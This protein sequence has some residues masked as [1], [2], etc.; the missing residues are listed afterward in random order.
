MPSLRVFTCVVL[1]M[2]L[3]L[4]FGCLAEE[5]VLEVLLVVD[6][7]SQ[8]RW[9]AVAKAAG[10][11]VKKEAESFMFEVNKCFRELT[12][13][14]V[15]IEVRLVNNSVFFTSEAI[16]GDDFLY[17]KKGKTYINHTEVLTPLKEWTKGKQFDIA[18]FI[19]GHTFLDRDVA[20][21][22]IINHVCKRSGISII[23]PTYNTFMTQ[24]IVHE[25]GHNLGLRHDGEGNDCGGD[26][27]LFM[28]P[29]ISRVS[30]EHISWSSCSADVLRKNLKKKKCIKSTD[31]TKAIKAARFGR[32]LSADE[33]C[34][35]LDRKHV[36][37]F[38][39]N[40]D[41]SNICEKLPCEK[42]LKITTTKKK[43]W[44]ITYDED[45]KFSGVW[46]NVRVP[47]GMQC[48]S[49]KSCEKGRCVKDRSVT[50]SWNTKCPFGDTPYLEGDIKTCQD[51]KKKKKCDLNGYRRACCKSCK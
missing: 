45:T 25:L 37:R 5:Y 27:K 38:A 23:K 44:F 41:Y 42:S 29:T 28:A 49:G 14:G 34:K 2:Y 26:A 40:H 36:S 32:I 17:R 24:T 19:P 22:A 11:T 15:D 12:S 13:Q 4:L 46:T 39:Y 33:L 43:L 47:P 3:S 30:Y 9:N 10:T 48:G 35:R 51:V 18:I 8:A 7:P 50:K 20:G 1:S 6:G 16:L 21:V 31:R